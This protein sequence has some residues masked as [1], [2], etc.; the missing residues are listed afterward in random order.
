MYDPRR[1]ASIALVATYFC[2]ALAGV[3]LGYVLYNAFANGRSAISLFWSHTR[4]D[5]PFHEQPGYALLVLC[6]NIALAFLLIA[7]ARGCYS[8]YKVWRDG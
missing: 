4:F 1:Q 3:Q 8:E 7:V 2:F 6:V 5:Y